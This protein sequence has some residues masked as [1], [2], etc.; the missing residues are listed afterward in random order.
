M[1][2]IIL[3]DEYIMKR[4]LSILL[5]A[6]LIVSISVPAFANSTSIE[7]SKNSVD[8][9]EQSILDFFAAIQNNDYDTLKSI[10]IN[11]LMSDEIRRN[12]LTFHHQEAQIIDK[13]TIMS[14]TMIAEDLIMVEVSFEFNG[15]ARIMTYPVVLVDN[16]WVVNVGDAVDPSI[17]GVIDLNGDSMTIQ[18]LTIDRSGAMP[19]NF[20]LNLGRWIISPFYIYH[21]DKVAYLLG[22]QEN[23]NGS[24]NVNYGIRYLSMVNTWELTGNPTNIL[25]KDNINTHHFF[26]KFT[27]VRGPGVILGLEVTVTRGGTRIWGNFCDGP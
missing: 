18:D 4:A 5:A 10:S 23:N 17:T 1:Q 21:S 3:G 7:K 27:N 24:V 9:A 2:I 12:T 8:C 22:F 20:T 19:Y 16:N 25:K 6:I 14:S 26:Q 11:R 15:E 13:I